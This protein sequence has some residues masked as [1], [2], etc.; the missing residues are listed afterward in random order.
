M[1]EISEPSGTEISWELT[2]DSL[3]LAGK[4]ELSHTFPDDNLLYSEINFEW[5]LVYKE[6]NVDYSLLLNAFYDITTSE[7][8][9]YIVESDFVSDVEQDDFHLLMMLLRTQQHKWIRFEKLSFLSFLDISWLPTLLSSPATTS[10]I[11]PDVN[12]DAWFLVYTSDL[13]DLEWLLWDDADT[14]DWFLIKDWIRFW[15]EK[16]RWERWHELT[17]GS[18]NSD[19]PQFEW[20][21]HSWHKKDYFSKITWKLTSLHW[22]SWD[23]VTQLFVKKSGIDV[24]PF[25]ELFVENTDIFP[26]L[27]ALTEPVVT[28]TIE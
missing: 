7:T 8:Y 17:I 6:Y 2:N 14:L 18:D 21:F 26:D 23:I 3:S 4:V 1:T 24:K 13:I 22:F 16:K 9:I 19:A 27:S 28:S 10:H 11:V 25:P 12:N 20:Y 15:L 5:T